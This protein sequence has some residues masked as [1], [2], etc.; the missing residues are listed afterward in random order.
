MTLA[1]ACGVVLVSIVSS[2]IGF[3]ILGGILALS[4][5]KPSV[6]SAGVLTIDL[7]NMTLTEQSTESNPFDIAAISNP[8]LV[9]VSN[10]GV[11]DAVKTLEIAADDPG[12]KCILLKS[13]GGDFSSLAAIEEFR[14]ALADFRQNSGK[15]VV[16]YIE[17]P[18]TRSY[19]LASV[20]DKVYMTSHIGATTMITGVSSQSFFLGDLL[21]ALKI[22]VQLIRHGKYKSAG[23]MYTRNSSSAENKL[24]NQRMVDALWEVIAQ[25]IATN[26]G[27][28]V[29]AL[30]STIDNLRLT[31]PQ[32]FVE[33]GL[34]DE[35]FNNDELRAKLNVLSGEENVSYIN[36]ADY[37]STKLAEQVSFSS[38]KIAIVYVDGQIVDG[39]AKQEVSGDRFASIIAKIRKDDSVKGVVLR[40]NS[41]GGSVLAS[42]KIKF[43][44]DE[45]GKVKPLVASYGEYAASGGYWISANCSK[46][47]SDATTLTGSIGVFSIIPDFSSTAKDLL[48]VGI[49]TVSSNKHANALSMLAPLDKTEYAFFQSTIELVYDKFTSI[50]SEGRSMAKDA[51]DEIGQGRVWVGKDAL[52]INL[53][54]EIGGLTQAVQYVASMAGDPNLSAWNI[55]AYPKPQTDIEKILS[56]FSK[57]GN[58]ENILVKTFSDIKSPA[59]WARMDQNV[60]IR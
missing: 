19:W 21:K 39:N 53:V 51:V 18:S 17:S 47:Y 36:F 50:V 46:I 28:S 3:T 58:E 45:L 6:P 35:L 37:S 11:L 57:S 54:D 55:A 44:L 1:A 26:R 22:N 8:N 43:E 42:E 20:A 48:K 5:A 60:V 15:A 33:Y 49:E 38:Q 59:V 14:K 24:Q 16:S 41:P 12:I 7:S 31:C 27:I 13:D 30:N 23:E 9:S 4:N 34:V 2:F 29:E 25:D 52:G 40:V 32:D 10:V 56:L